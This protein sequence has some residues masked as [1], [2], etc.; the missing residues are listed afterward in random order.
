M[1][2]SIF[3]FLTLLAMVALSGSTALAE[4]TAKFHS[5]SDR[6]S[7][8]GAL[9]VS[10]DQRGLGNDN[11][12][13]N[14]SAD[15]TANYQCETRGNG[16]NPDTKRT[17]NATVTAS[18][19]LQPKNGR[20]TVIDLE[21]GGPPPPPSDFECDGNGDGLNFGLTSVTYTNVKVVDTTNG[22]TLNLAN[23]SRTF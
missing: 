3:A 4:G 16:N 5:G 21:V 1:R 19:T 6:I 12:T 22:V 23:V 7:D 11:I 18:I 10:W 2:R 13:Y 15:A 20:I 8:S 9:L 17:V 14:M